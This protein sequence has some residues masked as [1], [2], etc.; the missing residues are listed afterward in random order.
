M[1]ILYYNPP[2]SPPLHPPVNLLRDFAFFDRDGYI[3]CVHLSVAFQCCLDQMFDLDSHEY[4]F[5]FDFV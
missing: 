2:P 5:E 4:R 3:P 1:E